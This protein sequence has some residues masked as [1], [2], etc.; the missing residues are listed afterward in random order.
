VKAVLAVRARAASVDLDE[1]GTDQVIEQVLGVRLVDE[2]CAEP[3]REDLQV[4]QGE[5]A[6][7]LPRLL[8]GALVAER[9]ARPDAH[10]AVS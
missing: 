2:H 6:E 9:D 1:V 4:E 10:V 5:S 3:A 8:A 7:Q